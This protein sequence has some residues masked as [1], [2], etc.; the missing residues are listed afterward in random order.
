MRWDSPPR[1]DLANIVICTWEWDCVHMGGG[2]SHLG[3]ISLPCRLRSHLGGMKIS[4]LNALQW[5]SPRWWDEFVKSAQV[6]KN[7]SVPTTSYLSEKSHQLSFFWISSGCSFCSWLRQPLL[8][9]LLV[10]HSFSTQKLN[11]KVEMTELQL[12][13]AVEFTLPG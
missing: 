8:N 5:A 3:E 9:Y 1:W 13:S 2:L 6:Q 10:L 4:H 7:W 11:R 12:S